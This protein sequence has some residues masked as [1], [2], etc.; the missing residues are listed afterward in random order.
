MM[1]P[2]TTLFVLTL[3]VGTGRGADDTADLV[4]R[5][6]APGFVDRETAARKLRELGV[7]ALPAVTAG[8]TSPDAEVSGRCKRLL[9]LLRA[10]RR[11]VFAAAFRGD[12]D[13]KQ[14]HDHPV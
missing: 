8:C 14:T 11:A 10:D 4:A 13:G 5:L 6:A 12:A 7:K 2:A 9:G 1:N 3:V